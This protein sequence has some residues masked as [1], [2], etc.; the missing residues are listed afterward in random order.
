M[1]QRT[2]KGPEI[3]TPSITMAFIV[4]SSRF[5]S[6]YDWRMSMIPRYSNSR[7]P[8]ELRAGIPPGLKT[9]IFLIK[10]V[11]LDSTIGLAGRPWEK[12]KH[13]I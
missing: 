5:L 13:F 6:R 2:W 10:T 3:F 9:S 11:N 1:P 12:Q 4:C 7:S 8:F